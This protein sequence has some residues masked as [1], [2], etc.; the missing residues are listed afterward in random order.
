[1]I[2]QYLPWNWWPVF[3]LPLDFGQ[4]AGV[5]HIR[6]DLSFINDAFSYFG[7]FWVVV[8]SV[9]GFFV[10]SKYAFDPSH[11]HEGRGK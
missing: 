6:V 10:V 5:Q 9:L 2:E 7:P 1:M 3:D 11:P 8:F 4:W